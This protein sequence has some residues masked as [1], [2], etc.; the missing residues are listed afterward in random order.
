MISIALP[1]IYIKKI[2]N[3]DICLQLH[4]YVCM[5]TKVVVQK[6]KKFNLIF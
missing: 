3:I 5:E 6:I 2:I 1:G 4:Y